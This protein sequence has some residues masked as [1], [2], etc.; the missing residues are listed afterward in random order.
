[1]KINERKYLFID[2]GYF[3]RV[4]K[5]IS[6]LYY[7]DI[8]ILKII[9]FHK[10]CYGYTKTFYYDCLPII[11]KDETDEQFKIRTK[12]EIKFYNSL[13][14]VPGLHVFNGMLRKNAKKNLQKGVDV[15]IAV[16]M[17]MHTINGNMQ[18]ASLL[19]GDSDFIP[20]LE[21]LIQQGMYVTL[22]YSPKYTSKDL[23]YKADNKGIINS[24]YFFDKLNL[25]H[26]DLYKIPSVVDG[27]NVPKDLPIIGILKS[28]HGTVND[29]IISGNNNVFHEDIDNIH[30]VYYY[31][32]S[33]F[34]GISVRRYSFSNLNL[35]KLRIEEDG[36]EVCWDKNYSV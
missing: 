31:Y 5:S 24:S 9:D 34:N 6:E 18:Q 1:M 2:G 33:Y 26:R 36:F 30:T 35:I 13:E 23:I 19:T 22:L 8:D 29:S 27:G 15:K 4:A 12:K 25:I 11:K 16:D 21:A 28:Y 14:M 17:L 10:V 20:L 3:R 7:P 32:H